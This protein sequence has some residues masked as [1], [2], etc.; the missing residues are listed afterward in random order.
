MEKKKRNA[1]KR[2]SKGE[3]KAIGT[4]ESKAIPRQEAVASEA[5]DVGPGFVDD[6]REGPCESHRLCWTFSSA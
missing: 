4:E 6:G 3:T 1:D 2:A 5:L